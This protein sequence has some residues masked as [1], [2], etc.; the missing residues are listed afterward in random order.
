MPCRVVYVCAR[1]FSRQKRFFFDNI[2]EKYYLLCAHNVLYKCGVVSIEKCKRV[3]YFR[4][5]TVIIISSERRS[6]R[7]VSN[8]I[9]YWNKIRHGARA[10]GKVNRFSSSSS[11]EPVAVG[12]SARPL[13][14][15]HP[16]AYH[17]VSVAFAAPP[18]TAHFFIA[19]P[20]TCAHFAAAASNTKIIHP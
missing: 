16:S 7:A 11:S 15:H 20:F 19:G 3:N 13:H 1:V 5:L 14:R 10:T 12:G 17:S 8:N 4:Q 2:I 9:Y 6:Q 18:G